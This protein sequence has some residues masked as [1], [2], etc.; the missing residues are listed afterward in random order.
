MLIGDL[1]G[2]VGSAPAVVAVLLAGGDRLAFCGLAGVCRDEP[3][4]AHAPAEQLI[5]G[6][7]VHDAS[8]LHVDDLVG[9]QDRGH[10]VRDD[11]DRRPRARLTQTGQDGLLD[12][13][14][15]GGGGIVEDEQLGLADH[16]ARQGDSLALTPREAGAA[17]AHTG[18]EPIGQPLDEAGTLRDVQGAPDALVVVLDTE[19]DVAADAVVEHEGL[20]RHER[21]DVADAAASHL[22]QVDAVDEHGARVGV[23]EA[24]E[25]VGQRRLAAAGRS[26]DRDRRS[27]RDVERDV[28]DGRVEV[29]L[30]G[31]G[32]DL[33]AYASRSVCRWLAVPD[34]SERSPKVMLPVASRTADT[35]FQPTTARGSSARTQ[36]SA[37]TGNARMEKR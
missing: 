37:R 6:A 36:P 18:L 23:D 15:D 11:E 12:T 10:P 21:G 7:V 22:T 29:R 19:R 13:G 30:A 3:F 25:E 34:G 17:L 33:V 9:E 16:G 27:G 32:L 20:L 24:H 4:V 2:R 1:L 14:V 31:L 8:G 28:D 26:D 35:R 5:V